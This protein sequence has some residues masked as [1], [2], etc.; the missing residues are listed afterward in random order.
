[1]ITQLILEASSLKNNYSIITK[2]GLKFI[3]IDNEW[4]CFH[5]KNINSSK[6]KHFKVLLLEAKDVENGSTIIKKSGLKFVSIE[7]EW[8]CFCKEDIE[9]LMSKD[10]R[11]VIHPRFLLVYKDKNLLKSWANYERIY[12]YLRK[13]NYYFLIKLSKYN[14]VRIYGEICVFYSHEEIVDYQFKF[15][16]IDFAITDRGNY[17]FKQNKPLYIENSKLDSFVEN[18]ECVLS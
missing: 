10:L 5:K 15:K 7:N 9:V 12:R 18:D 17:Y 3:S 13:N 16:N 4:T 14:Y 2:P 6:S 1:M 8:I 11:V